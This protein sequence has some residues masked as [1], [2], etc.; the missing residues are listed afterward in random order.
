[1]KQAMPDDKSVYL[2]HEDTPRFDLLF[3]L[4]LAI[5]IGIVVIPAMILPSTARDLNFWLALAMVP[6]YGV[7]LYVYIPRRYQIFTDRMR[8]VIGKPFVINLPFSTI[9]EVRPVS[10]IRVF[11]PGWLR[12]AFSLE[13]T[14]GV[15]RRRGTNV[16]ISPT[17]RDNFLSCINQALKAASDD[18][19]Y[20]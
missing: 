9:Q 14:V 13:G 12:M 15:I 11:V 19:Q 10:A 18:G 5:P 1:M 20:D 16:V 8:I 17:D 6:C 2:I 3:K 7:F 4:L